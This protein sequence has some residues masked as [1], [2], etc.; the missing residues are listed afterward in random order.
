MD[1][2]LPPNNSTYLV[3]IRIEKNDKPCYIVDIKSLCVIYQ[4]TLS[5]F[6]WSM[7]LG[8]L[9]TQYNTTYHFYFLNQCYQCYY[10][11]IREWFSY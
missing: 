4:S 11:T 8:E 6:N 10:E 1:F 5:K 7:T 9:I 2:F 3:T